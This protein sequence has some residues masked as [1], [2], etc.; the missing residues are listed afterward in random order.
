VVA[1]LSWAVREPITTLP[2]SNAGRSAL[3]AW[4][5]TAS[6]SVGG[7]GVTINGILP[8]RFATPRIVELDRRRAE[9]E[10][11]TVEEVAAAALNGVPAGR[12]GQ[13]DEL[14]AV[15]AFLASE[16]AAYINGALVPVDGGMLQS[17]G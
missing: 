9:Q 13:P 6:R 10:G 2:L 17:L 7:E 1:V 16:R 5:K 15:V 8:G 11:R 3:A 12:D 14:G 4:L